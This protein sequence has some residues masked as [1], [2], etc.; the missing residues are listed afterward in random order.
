MKQRPSA[1]GAAGRPEDGGPEA[2]PDP[3]SAAERAQVLA[4]LGPAPV[5]IDA[6]VRCS[7]LSIRA[8]QVALI[9]LALAGR[10]ARH[11]GGLISLMPGES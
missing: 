5:D 1:G 3:L 8:V 2:P 10:I 9:E 7:G 11:G 4:A 6:L